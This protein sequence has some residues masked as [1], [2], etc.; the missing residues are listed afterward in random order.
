MLKT[1]II[2]NFQSIKEATLNL[3]EFTVVFGETNCGK[4]ALIR[5]IRYA[6]TNPKGSLF[7]RDNEPA[8]SVK[9]ITTKGW[10]EW[11]KL[12]T[13]S[14][15]YQ[16]QRL[17]DPEPVMLSKVLGVPDEIYEIFNVKDVEF[18]TDIKL[19]MNFM[20]QLGSPFLV[21][22]ECSASTRA[23]VVG[24]ISSMDKVYTA[25]RLV[26]KDILTINSEAKYNSGLLVS[27][28]NDLLAYS[29]LPA[30]E[31]VVK[32]VES[33]IKILNDLDVRISRFPLQRLK[34]LSEA[35]ASKDERIARVSAAP[36]NEVKQLDVVMLDLGSR[37]EKI[38][39][40]ESL[41]DRIVSIESQMEKAL[42]VRNK[43][44]AALE[45][46]IKENPL[47]PVCGSNWTPTHSDKSGG[48]NV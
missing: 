48:A 9:I 37:S 31:L 19:S 35:L 29:D 4:S 14:A 32:D 47:C 42:M 40:L 34:S 22:S 38:S 20:S 7:V 39:K 21:S 23:K 27:M 24:K 30:R 12:S 18:D 8:C 25:M 41:R 16:Y 26:N 5:A 11:R 44:T 45:L 36:F 10:F 13:G 15:S 2:K 33:K 6:L 28:Q 43:S 46:L 17:E 1:V 3:E